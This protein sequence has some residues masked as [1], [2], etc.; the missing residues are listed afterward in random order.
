MSG[1]SH[2]A[3]VYGGNDGSIDLTFIEKTNYCSDNVFLYVY[4]KN[5]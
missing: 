5:S 2:D 1:T 3:T 4:M